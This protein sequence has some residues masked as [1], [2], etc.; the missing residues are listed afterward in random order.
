MSKK[1]IYIR[2]II[3]VISLLFIGLFVVIVNDIQKSTDIAEST[4]NE[5]VVEKNVFDLKKA[6]KEQKNKLKGHVSEYEDQVYHYLFKDERIINTAKYGGSFDYYHL[7]E[8]FGEVD[9]VYYI[10]KRRPLSNLITMIFSDEDIDYSQYAFTSNF[11]KNHPVSLKKEFKDCFNED[12]EVVKDNGKFKHLFTY[13]YH[14]GI[15]REK[16]QVEIEVE[17]SIEYFNEETGVNGGVVYGKKGS[18]YEGQ[19]LYTTLRR[20]YFDY[21]L[22]E[23]EYLDDIKYSH[24]QIINDEKELDDSCPNYQ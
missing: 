10:Y 7:I 18:K 12:Y 24:T 2:I 15:D 21:I 11:L 8:N 9:N 19:E 20:I 14:I 13:Y 3:V 17:K 1:L 4:T 6:P 16:Q 5:T 23:K 22:D